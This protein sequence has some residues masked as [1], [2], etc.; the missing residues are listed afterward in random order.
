VRIVRS[1]TVAVAE[2]II[3]QAQRACEPFMVARR[4]CDRPFASCKRRWRGKPTTKIGEEGEGHEG[5]TT[6]DTKSTKRPIDFFVSFSLRV[7]RVLRG[8]KPSRP[9]W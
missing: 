4:Y 9:S 1:E 6:K 7:L 8:D 2:V 5:Y 3:L